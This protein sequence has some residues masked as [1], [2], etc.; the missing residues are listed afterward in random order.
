MRSKIATISLL[1]ILLGVKTSSVFAGE[2]DTPKPEWIFCDDFESGD[3][4][5]WS[6]VTGDVRLVAPPQGSSLVSVPPKRGGQYVAQ[7]YYSIPASGAAHQDSNR[8]LQWTSNQEYDHLFV[9]G[10]VLIPANTRLHGVDIIQRKLMYLWTSNQLQTNVLDSWSSAVNPQA[11][12]VSFTHTPDGTGLAVHEWDLFP[13]PK[14][15]WTGVEVEIKLNTP[16]SSNGIFRLWIDDVLVY[17][18]LAFKTRV[19]N[20]GYNIIDFG[21]QVDRVNAADGID[22]YRY[23]DNIVISRARIRS[24]A[25]PQN[26]QTR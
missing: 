12:D 25:T 1:I 18:N 7:M 11:V 3:F 21:T 14:G 6:F 15:R 26:L 5:K 9:R 20:A 22:E 4:R 16:G 2:C 23:W 19:D 13:F 8:Y 17:E 10:Y 24:L